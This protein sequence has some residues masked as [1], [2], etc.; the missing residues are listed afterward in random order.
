MQ[1]Y[2]W[3]HSIF[4]V[5]EYSIK[6]DIIKQIWKLYI[7]KKLNVLIVIWN[8]FENSSRKEEEEEKEEEKKKNFIVFENFITKEMMSQMKLLLVL[9]EI[10][11]H[12]Q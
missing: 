6:H 3:H 2:C 8:G 11:L 7:E 10:I 4:L 12:K 5:L 1:T 9:L